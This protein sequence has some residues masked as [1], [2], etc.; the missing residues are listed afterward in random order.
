VSI[1]QNLVT[2][3]PD[4]VTR[5]NALWPRVRHAL[6]FK[7][8]GALYVL[9][10][11]I[12]LFGILR[13]SSFLTIS[14][15]K[16]ILNQNA[17][18]G[19]V[20]L[21]LVIPLSCAVYDL[22]VGYAMALVSVLIATLIVNSGAGNIETII[23]ALLLAAGAG[24]ANGLIVV[25]ARIHSFIGTL[26]SGAV[27]YSFVLLISNDESATSA[28]MNTS[29]GSIATAGIGGITVP[30]FVCAAIAVAIWWLLEHTVTGRR[31]YAT[32][33]NDVAA[34]LAGVRTKRLQFGALI[35]SA[36]IAGVAGLLLTSQ[37]GSGSPDIGPPYLLDAFA[38]AFLGSTQFRPGR[39]NAAGTI[40]AVLLL[41]TGDAGLT[42]VG[43]PEWSQSM[44]QGV[45]LL[46]ALGFNSIEWQRLRQ[47]RAGREGDNAT[48][49][50]VAPEPP[51][52][53]EAEGAIVG[54]PSDSL[55][56]TTQ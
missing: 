39:F 33:F 29:F 42:L 5:P 6:G 50:S 44:L 46:L 52:H 14:T 22:S 9:I 36:V 49:R 32:G 26:A 2:S 19:L 27:F 40:L 1:D 53:A 30:V 15:L 18:N 4:A 54:N 3:G 51:S 31:L 11:V 48:P 41:G 55:K 28:R 24:I 8:I 25:V 21:S 7:T 12:V 10:A 38:A 20:A 16:V 34:R 45:V 56:R 43:A 17:I 23:L 47:S 13:P 35:A 37:I